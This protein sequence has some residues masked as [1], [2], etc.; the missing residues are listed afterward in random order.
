[1]SK[2]KDIKC[3][4]CSGDLDMRTKV[5]ALRDKGFEWICGG[6]YKKE[7]LVNPN[8]KVKEMTKNK[9][10]EKPWYEKGIIGKTKRYFID[11]TF[12]D[13]KKIAGKVD[14]E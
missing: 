4:D 8:L 10:V 1:M 9:N 13:I 5:K 3:Y 2:K 14:K 7:M 11:D 12:N 6:C